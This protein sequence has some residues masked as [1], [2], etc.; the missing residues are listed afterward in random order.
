MLLSHKHRFIFIKTH[1]T[2]GTSIEVDLARFFGPDDIITPIIPPVEGH[3]PRNH[4]G[5]SWIARKLRLHYWNHMSARRVRRL[6]GPRVFDSYFKFCVEREPV[7]KCISHFSMLKKSPDHG[8]GEKQ[9]SW[10][11]YV[12]RGI[13][14]ENAGSWLDDDNTLLV[15]RILR[16]EDL[17]T[18]LAAVCAQLGISLAGVAA[19]AKAGFSSPIDVTDAQRSRIYAAFSRSLPFT[20]YTL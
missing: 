14:P 15:D 10:D 20:G 13:F 1:K 3:E 4:R 11:E 17:D 7:A 9:L 5:G 8:A 16:Y 12:E 6:A 2:A 19:R 18:E